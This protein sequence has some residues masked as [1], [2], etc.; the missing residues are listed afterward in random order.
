MNILLAEFN[1]NKA[2]ISNI[3]DKYNKTPFDYAKDVGDQNYII[4]KKSLEIMKIVKIF[5]NI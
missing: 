4:L 2:D 5:K 1:T 3:K